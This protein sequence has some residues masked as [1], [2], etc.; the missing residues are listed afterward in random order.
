MSISNTI[1]PEIIISL[2]GRQATAVADMPASLID[3]ESDDNDK[4]DFLKIVARVIGSGGS[5]TVTKPN[6]LPPET[7]QLTIKEPHLDGG[8]AGLNYTADLVVPISQ[9]TLPSRRKPET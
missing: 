4:E 3:G 6:N 8:F 1:S 9:T 2:D 7:T 5:V